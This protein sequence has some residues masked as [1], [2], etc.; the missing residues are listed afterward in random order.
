MSKI[1]SEATN[2]LHHKWASAILGSVPLESWAEGNNGE[3][4]VKANKDA[5]LRL[6]SPQAPYYLKEKNTI[7]EVRKEVFTSLLNAMPSAQKKYYS[8]VFSWVGDKSE[9][10]LTLASGPFSSDTVFGHVLIYLEKWMDRQVHESE[11][12]WILENSW[13]KDRSVPAEVTINISKKALEHCR[14]T[15][16]RWFEGDAGKDSRAP[17]NLMPL[18]SANLSANRVL[19]E[20]A[21]KDARGQEATDLVV[22]ILEKFNRVG[23]VRIPHEIYGVALAEAASDLIGLLKILFG[24]GGKLI[25]EESGFKRPMNDSDIRIAIKMS[26][27]LQENYIATRGSRGGPVEA[28]NNHGNSHNLFIFCLVMIG[29]FYTNSKTDNE[30]K[31]RSNSSYAVFPARNFKSDVRNGTIPVHADELLKQAYGQIYFGNVSDE[32]LV[33]GIKKHAEASRVKRAHIQQLVFFATKFR[34]SNSLLELGA[35]LLEMKE[36]LPLSERLEDLG[37]E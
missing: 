10:P 36:N 25:C 4:H 27:Q 11:A 29:A 23:I 22:G 6:W 30:F 26:L 34:A 31:G 12:L 17:E 32:I 18:I 13:P 15:L 33:G 9:A 8:G 14:S 21:A 3:K 20:F 28:R 7:A 16:S 24:P 37:F 19:L 2:M 1:F 5:S 35:R